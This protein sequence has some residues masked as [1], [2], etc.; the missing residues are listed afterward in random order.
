MLLALQWVNV[1]A[2]LMEGETFVA[3]IGVTGLDG[4]PGF[5]SA[6]TEIG[7]LAKKELKDGVTISTPGKIITGLEFKAL[8]TLTDGDKIIV[9]F[10]ILM[11]SKAGAAQPIKIGNAEY[12]FSPLIASNIS[13]KVT[14]DSGKAIEIP[15]GPLTDPD[16]PTSNQYTIVMTATKDPKHVG[17]DWKKVAKS[18]ERLKAGMTGQI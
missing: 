6:M 10:G 2:K 11:K 7:Y 4:E 14:L 8:S 5:T 15:F 1:S 16:D 17:I 12:Q 9:D 3:E 18:Y 13:Q